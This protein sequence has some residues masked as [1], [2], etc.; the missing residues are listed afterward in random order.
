VSGGV[1]LTPLV[2]VLA[3]FISVFEDG[4]AQTDMMARGHKHTTLT[5]QS[6]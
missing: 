2:L 4:P 5:N 1:G 6:Q 3:L